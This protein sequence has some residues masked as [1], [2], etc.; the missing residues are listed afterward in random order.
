MNKTRNFFEAFLILVLLTAPLAQ[1]KEGAEGHGGE[2]IDIDKRPRLR[3]LVDKTACAWISAADFGAG[4]SGFGKAVDAIDKVHWYLAYAI[5]DEARSL[6]VC[7]TQS[8]LKQIP[9]DD[10]EGLTI[11]EVDTKQVAIRLNNMI[12][13]DGTL[14]KKLPTED[15]AYLLLHE[16]THS[17]IPFDAKRR[18][19]KVRNFVYAMSQN[20]KSLMTP[21]QFALQIEQ[22]ELDI[23]SNVQRFAAT[24]DDVLLVLDESRPIAEREK[25]AILASEDRYVMRDKDRAKI[26]QLYNPLESELIDAVNR[27]DEKRF[28]E[29]ITMGLDPNLVFDVRIRN[30]S[31]TSS[32]FVSDNTFL[33]YAMQWGQSRIEDFLLDLPS[34]DVNQQSELFHTRDGIQDGRAL[35]AGVK[36]APVLI[37]ASLRNKVGVVRRLLTHSELKV[38]EHVRHCR[39]VDDDSRCGEISG[40]TALHVARTGAMVDALLSR[41]DI[42]V[43]A[44]GR[45]TLTPLMNYCRGNTVS[46]KTRVSQK[47]IVRLLKHP[48]IDPNIVTDSSALYKAIEAGDLNCVREILKHPKTNPNLGVSETGRTP[49]HNVV[50]Y[51]DVIEKGPGRSMLYALVLD[52]RTNLSLKDKDGFTALDLAIKEHETIAD[53]LRDAIKRRRERN[54]P[55]PQP[56]KPTAPVK[57]RR[58][59]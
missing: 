43:N 50:I 51:H 2:V 31:Y 33:G 48:D 56:K 32:D 37:I 39:I 10:Q 1:A 55:K 3:D 28:A 27:G 30:T 19:S 29:L 7:M 20:E 18:A 41:H 34:L 8:A 45:G 13:I 57:P 23:V 9:E 40:M 58:G 26:E 15:R 16:I 59:N 49:L 11:Y 36:L 25:S 6:S 21:Q 52:S 53:V 4:I 38:N 47:A 35:S 46:R 24:K 44:I 22:N 14:F 17:F 54:R 5:N 42:D 12:F